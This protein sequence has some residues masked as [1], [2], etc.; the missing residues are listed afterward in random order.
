MQRKPHRKRSFTHA[1]R[2][3]LARATEHYLA[4]CYERR[5]AAR[6]S[7]FASHL[8]RNA[9]YLSRIVPEI[10]GASLQ[11]YLRQQQ[12]TY[13]ERLLRT[14]PADITVTEIALRSGFGSYTTLYR[15]FRRAFGTAPTAFREVRK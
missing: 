7:E 14:L 11:D 1:H 15:R 2:Q 12:L 4:W 10:I 5:T 6:V 8:G 9:D 3:R 13:A